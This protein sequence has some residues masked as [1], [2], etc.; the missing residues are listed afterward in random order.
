MINYLITTN[1]K[2]NYKIMFF[3]IDREVE[4]NFSVSQIYGKKCEF[5]TKKIAKLFKY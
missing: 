5:K 4:S 1:F 3:N 2:I